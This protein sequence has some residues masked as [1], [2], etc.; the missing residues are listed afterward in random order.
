MCPVFYVRYIGNA[1]FSC[2][3]YMVTLVQVVVEVMGWK[4]M[5]L[6]C[7]WV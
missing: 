3:G 4:K 5:H 2:D 6:L 1:L 7:Q